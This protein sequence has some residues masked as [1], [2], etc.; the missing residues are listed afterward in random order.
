MAADPLCVVEGYLS[1]RDAYDHERARTFL[2]DRGFS[3]KSP[4]AQIDSADA[5][6][7]Y[8]AL[9]GGIVLSIQ[10]RKVFVDGA[11]VCHLLTYRVQLSEK[12]SVE[13]AH[14]AQVRDGRI[15][16]IEVIFDAS[17]YRTLFPAD[18]PAGGGR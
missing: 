4:I 10:R 1:A 5:F 8:T 15:A 3:F 16:R 7:Q 6:I 12:L 18:E 2:A 14:W 17:I 13:V 11:D 9:A